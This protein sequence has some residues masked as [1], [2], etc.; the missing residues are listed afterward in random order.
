MRVPWL[1]FCLGLGAAALFALFGP[2]PEAWLYDRAAIEAGELWRLVTGHMVHSDRVHLA[3]NLGALLLLG[4]LA[5]L[6]LG[7]RALIGPLVLGVIAI[8][9][10]LWWAEP[11]LLRYCGLSGLLNGLFVALAL[12]LWRQSG[13]RLFLLLAAGDIAKIA[14]EAHLGG[15]LLPTTSAL[16]GPVPGAHLVGFGAGLAAALIPGFHS[17]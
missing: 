9:A 3:W 7:A 10:W 16:W 14:L 4:G 5:E 15:A 11:A 8:D 13:S 6:R 17:D 2:A 1:T 12:G